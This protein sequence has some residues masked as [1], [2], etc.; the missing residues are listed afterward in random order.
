MKMVTAHDGIRTVVRLAGRLDGESAE[1]LSDTL[2]DL[3]RDGMRAVHLDMSEIDYISSAGTQMLGRRY[4]DFSFIRGELRIAA[5]SPVVLEALIQS[6]LEDRL[7][8]ESGEGTAAATPRLS[9][10]TNRVSDVTR[11]SW[12]T[13]TASAPH[14]QY[15]VSIRD[16]A[17]SMTCYTVGD[18]SRLGKGGFRSED[19]KPVI[20]SESV[21]GLGVG[22]IGRRAEDCVPRL[23]EL[24]GLAGVV[25][26]LPTDGSRRPDFQIGTATAPADVML[27]TGLVLQG[28]FSL[29]A[30]FRT[31]P[32][33]DSVPLSEIASTCLQAGW[34]A[35]GI[36]IAA[37]AA[38]LVG[39]GLRRSPAGTGLDFAVPEVREWLAFR[40]ERIYEESTVLLVGVVSRQPHRSLAPYLR[41]LGDKLYGHFHAA[42]FPY[43]PLP[44][45]SVSLTVLVSRVFSVRK[46]KGVFHLLADDRGAAGPGQTE[47]LR[48][49][50]WASPITSLNGAAQ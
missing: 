47:L 39:A 26:Y 5:P 41:P 42:A 15:E 8:L 44:R 30:R 24:L 13:T 25:T 14:G 38:G 35:A 17:A 9:A 28:E 7:L 21:V 3:L 34:G 46:P 32:E 48:G 29:L 12:R 37:E 20:F 36:V 40:P 18:P 19:C 4:Q 31:Q 49:L 6:G 16:S 22:A 33:T 45:R 43:G 50:C 11:D 27:V 23:G 1:H 2:D 10:L